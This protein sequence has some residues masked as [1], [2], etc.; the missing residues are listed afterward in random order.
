VEAIEV[1]SVKIDQMQVNRAEGAESELFS[2]RFG[3]RCRE[4]GPK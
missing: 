4:I 3:R 1:L 2:L